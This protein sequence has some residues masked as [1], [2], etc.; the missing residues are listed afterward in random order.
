MARLAMMAEKELHMVRVRR[1]LIVCLMA[2]IT[3]HIHEL[4]VSV[5][6]ARLAGERNM[7]PGQWEIGQRVVKRRRRPSAGRVTLRAVV[8]EAAHNMIRVCR[9]VEIV[10]VAIVAHGRQSVIH[11]VHV[12]GVA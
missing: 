1:D 3:V 6:V 12:T 4:I 7:C 5:D 10:R 9:V 2:L 11:V 8:T